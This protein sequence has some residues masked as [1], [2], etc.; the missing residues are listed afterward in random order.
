LYAEGSVAAAAKRVP[1]APSAAAVSAPGSRPDAMTAS[2]PPAP[3]VRAAATL[4]PIPP[5]PQRDRR[6]PASATSTSAPSSTLLR[7]RAPGSAG[8]RSYTPSMSLS[9]TSMR[10]WSMMATW[11]ARAS[12]SPNVISSVAVESFS[13]TTAT[14][15]QPISR[16]SVRRAFT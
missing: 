16:R 7:R 13:F 14:T 2:T 1:A 11:A 12:L 8:S 15:S 6:P 4:L 9:R 10:A 5:V 3:A